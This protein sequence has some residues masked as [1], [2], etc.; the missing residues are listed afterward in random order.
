MHLSELQSHMCKALLTPLEDE[1]V[2]DAHVFMRSTATLDACE[3]LDI[4]RRS[5]WARIVDAF[6]EDFPGLLAVLGEKTF[7]NLAYA[8]LADHPS[9]SFTLRDLGQFLEAWLIKNPGFAKD[10]YDCALDMIRFEWAHIE[11]FDAEER[12]AL[13]IVELAAAGARTRFSLQ[14]HI[15][16]LQ[17]NHAVDDIRIDAHSGENKS[18]VDRS[19]KETVFLILHRHEMS[20]H[21]LT[22]SREEWVLLSL[23]QKGYSLES[24]ISETFKDSPL[25]GNEQAKLITACFHRWAQFGWLCEERKTYDG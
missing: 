16:Q 14:P 1:V 19:R 2:T 12:T 17:V 3:R 13:G 9:Q 8:Y 4:Y 18:D 7:N 24:A 20:V 21:Y 6:Y 10:Q 25:E 15:R 22:T 11:A 23:L 5:Y